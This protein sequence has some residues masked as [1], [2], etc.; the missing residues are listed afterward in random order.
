MR[1]LVAV[2][3]SDLHTDYR[4]EKL[5]QLPVYLAP[6]DEH[7][8]TGLDEAWQVATSGH[9]THPVT[10]SVKGRDLAVPRANGH[11]AFFGLLAGMGSVAL[12]FWFTNIAF[13]WHNG[14]GAVAVVVIGTG[15]SYLTGS[16]GTPAAREA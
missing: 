13:L 12:V 5:D 2:V 6:L 15:I 8:R 3:T 4:R 7:A 16:A 9:E 14:V 1:A 10:L 11:G